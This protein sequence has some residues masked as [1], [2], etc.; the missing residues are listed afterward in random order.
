MCHPRKKEVGLVIVNFRM[1]LTGSITIHIRYIILHP[2]LKAEQLLKNYM[3]N[4]VNC[5]TSIVISAL[6]NTVHLK[7]ET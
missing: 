5:N 2:K 3:I 4:V 7:G 6:G 1:G